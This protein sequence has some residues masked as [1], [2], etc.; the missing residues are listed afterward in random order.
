MGMTI[1]KTIDF[2][3]GLECHTPQ[4]NMNE[5]KRREYGMLND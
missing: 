5:A 1:D 4:A 2:F 3:N